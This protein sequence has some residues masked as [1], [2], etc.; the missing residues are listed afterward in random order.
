MKK[1]F[2]S[3]HYL[4]FCNPMDIHSPSD[5]LRA[6]QTDDAAND[7]PCRSW[8]HRLIVVHSMEEAGE[9]RCASWW[10]LLI[11][12][13]LT[14]AGLLV[15]GIWTFYFF[16]FYIAMLH[17]FGS[18]L[19]FLFPAISTNLPRKGSDNQVFPTV[20]LVLHGIFTVASSYYV[21][22][23][24]ADLIFKKPFEF[25]ASTPFPF[26]FYLFDVLVMQARMRLRYRYAFVA[27]FFDTLTDVIVYS[28]RPREI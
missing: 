10:L 1:F 8:K 18:T 23:L 13:S 4:N 7:E 20:T 24:G 22:M 19:W 14:T 2:A 9:S 12:R 11:T 5:A 21:G 15:T 27:T 28:S 25:V 26:R 16:T 3:A 6:T 17:H